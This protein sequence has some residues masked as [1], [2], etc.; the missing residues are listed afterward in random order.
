MLVDKVVD[1]MVDKVVDKMVD[2]WGGAEVPP[3]LH[4][5]VG[6]LRWLSTPKFST[7]FQY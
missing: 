3:L 2:T 5:P 1:K 7:N 4:T 6:Q